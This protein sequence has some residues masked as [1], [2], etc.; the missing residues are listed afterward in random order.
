[1]TTAVE[2]EPSVAA[3]VSEGAKLGT[4]TVRSGE[5]V[6]AQ[7]PLVA[8]EEAPRLTFSDLFR[9]VLGRVAMAG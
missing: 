1:M 6:L 2:L 5:Q 4:L 3:P 7:L 9:Q 8:A